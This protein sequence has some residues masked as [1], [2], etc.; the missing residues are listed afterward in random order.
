MKRV[1]RL[2]IIIL[3]LVSLTGCSVKRRDV[4]T[5]DKN[6]NVSFELTIALD[7]EL[8]ENILK[9]ANSDKNMRISDEDKWN[10]LENAVDKYEDWTKERYSENGYK[11]F[12]LKYNKIV[13]LD[14][15]LMDN[16]I[17]AKYVFLSNINVRENKLFKLKD[18]VYTSIMQ[19]SPP[20]EY[21]ALSDGESGTLDMSFTIKLPNRPISSNADNTSKD[22]KTL[23]WNINELKDVELQFRFENNTI[24]LYIIVII[25]FIIFGISLIFMIKRKN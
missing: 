18:D 8:L 15:I 24:Y 19:V 4:V 6:K 14:D 20:R 25:L 11:G 13:R 16:D 2:L 7:D 9:V 3:V 10:Y 22:G 12:R 17:D 23:T 21:E 1:Y 5:I